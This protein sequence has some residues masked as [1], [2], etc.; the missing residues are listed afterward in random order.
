MT[1]NWHSWPLSSESSLAC[2]TY[3]D[4]GQPFIMIISKDPWHSH[5]LPNVWQWSCHYLFQ[6]LFRPGIKPR[7]PACQLNALPLCHLGVAKAMT[8][9]GFHWKI[10]LE[11]TYRIDLEVLDIFWPKLGKIESD[12]HLNVFLFVC[13]F[14]GGL[15]SHSRIFHSYEE[16][17]I[18]T[19]ARHL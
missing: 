14:V 7:S 10:K 9:V 6:R 2:H 17:Q 5:L 18:L 16:L 19:Y 15:S 12:I 1:Y 4:T 8:Y 11:I 3:C 13:L